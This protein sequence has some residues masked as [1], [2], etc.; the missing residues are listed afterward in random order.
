MKFGFIAKHR[1]DWPV[2]LM[3][4]A[5]GVSRG[6]FYAWLTRLPSHRS[7]Q[8]EKLGVQVRQSFLRSD[9]TY[10]ARRVWRDVL[11]QGLSCGLHRI[12]RLMRDQALRARP[13]RRGLPKDRGA[14]SAVAEHLLD[15]QFQA[16]APNQKWV[17][18]FTYIWT[19]EGWLYVAAVLDL[20]SRRIVGWSMQDSMTSQLVVDALMMGV[21][22]RGKPTALLHHS[23]SKNVCT[24]HSWT[25]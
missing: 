16:E 25:S 12:E 21:W 20:Y 6:G 1:G 11:E 18:D 10:G 17:A 8:D 13:R 15:R 23:D 7:R 3:C 9:R 22:R 24:S 5:L 4:E 19:A 14:R 2:N